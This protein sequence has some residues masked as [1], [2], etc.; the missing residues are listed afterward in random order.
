[1]KTRRNVSC[2]GMPFGRARKSPPTRPACCGR[3]ARCPPS[4][5]RR[6]PPRRPRSRGCRP[7]GGRTGS[8]GAGRRAPRS[9][10]LGF[11]PCRSFPVVADG[12]R[13]AWPSISDP[14]SSCVNP[15]RARSPTAREARSPRPPPGPPPPSREGRPTPP[16]HAAASPE[17][18][19]CPCPD[20]R[21]TLVRRKFG[22]PNYNLEDIVPRAGMP[23]G[24]RIARPDPG[25]SCNSVQEPRALAR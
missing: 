23:R 5:R 17:A 16:P 11:R 8:S 6:R 4:S 21:A 25:R 18:S 3:R 15:G 12:E 14:P 1:M 13:S 7:A 9:T 22:R 20:V 10:P 2:E 19:S 24:N